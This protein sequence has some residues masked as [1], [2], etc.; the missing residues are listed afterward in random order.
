LALVVF[1]AYAWACTVYAQL[2]VTPGSGPSGATVTVEGVQFGS[3]R[4]ELRWD[5]PIGALL[6]ETEGPSF[7]VPVTIPQD[8][9]GDHVIIAVHASLDPMHSPPTASAG[10]ARAPFLVAPPRPSDDPGAGGGAGAGGP[11]GSST[12]SG[13]AGAAPADGPVVTSGSQPGG[14]RSTQRRE[15]AGL[16]TTVLRRA[17]TF[18]F[19]GSLAQPGGA[20]LSAPA[21]VWQQEEPVIVGETPVPGRPSPLMLGVALLSVGLVSIAAGALLAEVTSR[22]ARRSP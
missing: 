9:P 1:G 12:G 2:H 11:S 18:V 21:R 17:G 3:G 8:E 19:R 4:V 16:P 15:G 13:R 5:S 20:V 14:E 7:K 6:A 22:R 10:Y